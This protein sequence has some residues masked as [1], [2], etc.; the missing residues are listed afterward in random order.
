MR[1]LSSAAAARVKVIV[2]RLWMGLFS[3]KSTR[4]RMPTMA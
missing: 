1:V 4:I 2:Q 3:S